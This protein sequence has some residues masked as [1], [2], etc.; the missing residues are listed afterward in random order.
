MKALLGFAAVLGVLALAGTS[1]SA[2]R[3]ASPA[4]YGSIFQR[5]AACTIGNTGPTPVKV[6]ARIFDESGNVVP[7]ASSCNG[8]VQPGF[9]CQVFANNIASGVAYACNV[10]VSGSPAKLRATLVL[11]DANEVPIRTVDLR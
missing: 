1:H 11:R 5:S 6:T 4:V 7:A 2:S 8:P 10:D 3:I 9:I